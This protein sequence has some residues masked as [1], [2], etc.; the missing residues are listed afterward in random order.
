MKTI[1]PALKQRL[2]DATFRLTNEQ[3]QA[4]EKRYSQAIDTM[5]WEPWVKAFYNRRRYSVDVPLLMRRF[6]DSIC[7]S[8]GVQ[9]SMYIPSLTQKR[10]YGDDI[11]LRFT[12]K[13][14]ENTQNDPAFV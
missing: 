5:N 3:V 8:I 11:E 13:L 10:F 9:R 14:I 1:Q 6:A 2:Y 4:Q 7:K 12:Q